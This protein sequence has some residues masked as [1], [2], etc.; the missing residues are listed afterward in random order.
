VTD[1]PVFGSTTSAS[2]FG[3]AVRS[4]PFSLAGKQAAFG[5]AR[6]RGREDEEDEDEEGQMIGFREDAISF[7]QARRITMQSAWRNIRS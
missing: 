3:T 1:F 4:S 5:G 6:G 7:E 2:V